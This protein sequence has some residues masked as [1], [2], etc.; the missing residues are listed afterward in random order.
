MEDATG[1]QMEPVSQPPKRRRRRAKSVFD[2]SGDMRELRLAGQDQLLLERERDKHNTY[3]SNKSVSQ[4]FLNTAIITQ[5]IGIVVSLFSSHDYSKPFNGFEIATL[6]LISLSLILQFTVFVMIVILLK[7][8]RDQA[9][10]TCTATALNSM[11]TSLSALSLIVNIAVT[12]VWIEARSS[13][14]P[15]SDENT[16]AP[17]L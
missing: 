11:V 6:V 2:E 5:Y 4:E 15:Q 9:T 10:K 12:A 7:A 14:L 16:T 3:S 8:S 17:G 1:I 13:T